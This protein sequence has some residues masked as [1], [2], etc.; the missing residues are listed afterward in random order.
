[1]TRAPTPPT[2]RPIWHE[3]LDFVERGG[4]PV[5]RFTRCVHAIV[6]HDRRRIYID[7]RCGGGGPEVELRHDRLDLDLGLRARVVRVG[8]GGAEIEDVTAWFEGLTPGW[9]T[10]SLRSEGG[11]RAREARARGA[12]SGKQRPAWRRREGNRPPPPPPPPPP[13]S[14]WRPVVATSDLVALG[15]AA[16][17]ADIAALKRAWR[18]AA[19]RLHPD[20]GGDA[21]EFIAARAAYER[22]ARV[23]GEEASR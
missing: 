19:Q 2:P 6:R 18:S 14:S 23:V 17:P 16:Q 10:P 7:G 11:E 12:V 5:A 4:R 20:H 8:P 22:L 13:W 1:M 9:R 15:L 21:T 3:I